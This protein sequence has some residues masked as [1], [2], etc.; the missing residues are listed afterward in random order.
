MKTQAHVRTQYM[1]ER[2][3]CTLARA[4]LVNH[5]SAVSSCVDVVGGE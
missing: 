4:S 5:S 2:I 3:M 1:H